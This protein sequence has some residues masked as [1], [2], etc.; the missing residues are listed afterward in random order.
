MTGSRA[1]DSRSHFTRSVTPGASSNDGVG[2]GDRRLG[3][4]DPID[5]RLVLPPEGP[6]EGQ[7][8]PGG[9]GAERPGLGPE[10]GAGDLGRTPDA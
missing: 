1:S 6:V 7:V 2:R 9:H 8:H 10:I 4:V 5:D 3:L